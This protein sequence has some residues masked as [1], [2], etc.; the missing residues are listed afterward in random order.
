MAK[1]IVLYDS[2][3]GNTEAMAKAVVE[4]AM[5]VKDV[6]VE[7]YKVG[8]RFP[9]SILNSA[10]AIIA[11]SPNVYGNATSEMRSF[12][13][14]MAELAAAK[15]LVLKGKPA[16]VFGCYGWDGGWAVEMLAKSLRNTGMKIV[17]PMVS[18]PEKLG[19]KTEE[20]ELLL[21]EC[22]KLGNVI[23]SKIART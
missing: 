2:F 14:S 10:D 17:L 16:G 19:I 13:T 3:T 9:M 8:T 7:L 23:A 6:Q 4:G 20:E 1:I 12:V 11:G 21:V 15:K 18:A 22:R 5:Q